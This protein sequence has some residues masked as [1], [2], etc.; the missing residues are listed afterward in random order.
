MK[1]TLVVFICILSACSPRIHTSVSNGSR[2]P[3][4][5]NAGVLVIDSWH[6]PPDSSLL[7]GALKIDNNVFSADCGYDDLIR[8]AKTAVR[9][10]GGNVL[11]VTEVLEPDVRNSCYRIKANMLYC[12]NIT[13][14]TA[15][16]NAVEDSITKS[17]FPDNPN[18]AL[19]YIYRPEVPDGYLREYNIHLNDSILCRVKND[20]KYEIKLYKKGINAVWA[21]TEAR[22]SVLMNVKFG[23]E[24]FLKCTLKMGIIIGRPDMELIPKEQGRYEYEHVGKR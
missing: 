4:N 19:L 10:A 22:D 5:T 14:V 6:L 16:L 13:K 21:E 17:K 24:Y 7:I 8:D 18:Y 12:P 1:I 2:E 9:K 11:K 3:L 23:Q 15:R 20:S